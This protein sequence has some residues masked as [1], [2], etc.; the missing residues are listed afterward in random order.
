MAN[1]SL[2]EP[3]NDSACKCCNITWET[4]SSSLMVA[5]KE[6]TK[7]CKTFVL[8]LLSC[9]VIIWIASEKCTCSLYWGD[10]KTHATNARVLSTYSR[11]RAKLYE[12]PLAKCSTLHVIKLCMALMNRLNKN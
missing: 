9:S 11:A 3:C 6:C 1:W 8:M 7:R 12:N 5:K 2:Y 4:L 10:M